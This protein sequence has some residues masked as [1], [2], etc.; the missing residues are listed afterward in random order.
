MFQAEQATLIA[1]PFAKLALM[2]CAHQD[3]LSRRGPPC[4]TAY[5]LEH[6]LIGS[7]R[8]EETLKGFA[9]VNI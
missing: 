6:H 7:D 9:S 1:R 4:S 3:C 8:N 5:V 2:V